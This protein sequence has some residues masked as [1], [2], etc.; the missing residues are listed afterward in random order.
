MT[1]SVYLSST[2][3]DLKDHREAVYQVLAKM[4]YK[5]IAMEDYVA[6][7]NRMVD[8]VRRDVAECDIYLGI[9]AW[10]YGYVPPQ[11]NPDGFSVTEL[12]YR[13]AEAN[14][15][16]RLLFLADADAPWSPKFMDSE[17]G[18]NERGARIGRL[19]EK[20][21]DRMH[22]LFTTPKDLAIET[23]AAVHLA[24]VD[25]K[26]QALSNDISS[27]SCLT[28]N[29]SEVPEIITNI[30]RAITED[31]KADLIKINLGTG[32]SWWSTRLHLLSALCAEYTEVR[33]MLFE[34]EGFRFVGMCTPSQARRALSQAFP[35]VEEA[36]RASVPPPQNGSFNP[37]DDVRYIVDEF[38]AA[39]DRLGGEPNVMRWVEPH[40]IQNWPGVNR[41]SVDLPGGVVTPPLLTSVVQRNTPFVVLVRDGIVQK[42]VDRA[43]LATR[44]A[45][46]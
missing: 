34:T 21:T 30:R 24:E 19:R 25:A 32:K 45:I 4:R 17:T 18:E 5:V 26:T 9:F 11:E 31:I 2:Y 1:K 14:K 6:R 27:A 42:V 7:D 20:L 22:S 23:A 40:V 8:Q 43:A 38:S 10:R 15:K 3:Q 46:V 33:Q 41:D 36:Y 44:M 35:N 29:T 39:M 28:M 16:Q 13:A 37:V 12:E